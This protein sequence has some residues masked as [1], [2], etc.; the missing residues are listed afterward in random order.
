[1]ACPRLP[2]PHRPSKDGCSTS[3]SKQKETDDRERDGGN[4]SQKK[5]NGSVATSIST[6]QSILTLPLGSATIQTTMVMTTQQA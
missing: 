2:P 4:L 6:P 5:G 3:G 1:M